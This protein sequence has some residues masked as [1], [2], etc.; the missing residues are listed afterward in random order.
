MDR[1]PPSLGTN[2]AR[3]YGLSVGGLLL[4]LGV[5][6]GLFAAYWMAMRIAPHAPRATMFAAMAASAVFMATLL[7]VHPTYSSDV[8]HY[9]ATARVTFVYNANPHLVPPDA[10][11]DDPLMSLSGWKTLP[12]PY[13]AGWSWLSAL[14]YVVSD[15]LST[16][17]NAVLAFKTLVVLCA[18]GAL[19]GVVV[20]AERLRRGMGTA[21]AVAFGWNPLV[22]LHFAGDGHNDAAMVL[23]LAWGMAA[24]AAGW[25]SATVFLFALAVLI[26]P[27]AGL[28]L[29]MLSV[30]LLR[31]G[32]WRAL[33]R[34]LLPASA[35]AVLLYLPFWE[36]FD[37]LRPM[38]EEGG[39][40]TGTP[41]SVMRGLLSPFG[42][43]VADL[44]SGGAVRL[45][46]L[47]SALALAW[48]G[49]LTP[50][51]LLFR[52]GITY[53]L[54]VTVLNT[55]YQPWYV[56]WAV[57]F[58]SCAIAVRDE[59]PPLV[60]AL[61]A[62]GLLVPVATN[63]IVGI[64]GRPAE[65]PLIDGLGAVLV[66]A[67]LAVASITLLRYRKAHGPEIQRPVFSPQ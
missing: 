19:A 11:P 52:I 65:D 6:A 12:S 15:G 20:T 51:D 30:V 4:Y 63:F 23:F 41:A 48:K 57:V 5:A 49:R 46:L 24:L 60:L 31:S 45:L 17:A 7:W 64:S 32:Q 35:V 29:L 56:S 38:V 34:G 37:T 55:W 1:V 43:G 27:A 33:A 61:T 58:L 28:A 8:L 67:P 13:G 18:L 36:G 59:S 16:A 22:I 9:V 10:F 39:Y 53:L 14:P 47:A 42:D 2:L 25:W 40:F 26:K 54:A 3:T 50:V 66:L 21:A 62:G 44:L